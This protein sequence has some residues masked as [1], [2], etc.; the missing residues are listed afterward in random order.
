METTTTEFRIEILRPSIN[1]WRAFG[2]D[3]DSLELAKSA[4]EIYRA[5][6]P[7]AKFRIARI[8]TTTTILDP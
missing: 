2:H 1:H 8:E 4:K 6:N 5:R 7:N 3:Q